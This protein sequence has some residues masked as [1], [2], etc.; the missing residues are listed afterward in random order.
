MYIDVR[1]GER[2]LEKEKGR[3]QVK[4]VTFH[5]ANS[6]HTGHKPRGAE[7]RGEI[8]LTQGC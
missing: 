5:L 4:F 6:I 7:H 2:S 3:S 8:I 1:R